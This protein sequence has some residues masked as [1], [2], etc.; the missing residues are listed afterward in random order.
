MQGGEGGSSSSSRLKRSLMERERRLN[1]KNLFAHLCSLLPPKPT[2][3][4]VL[5]LVDEAREYV[6]QKQQRMEQLKQTKVQLENDYGCKV[7]KSIVITTRDSDSCLEVNLVVSAD[8]KF[9]LSKFL[10]VL[11]EEGAQV[12]SAMYHREGDRFICSIQSQ[13]IC[14]RIGIE[15]S[16]VRERLE[17]LIS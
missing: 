17:G 16:R 9:E 14:S 8:L 5:E 3:M 7:G 13:A 10:I 4:T 2:K 1:M 6:K 15:T 11:E 12:T